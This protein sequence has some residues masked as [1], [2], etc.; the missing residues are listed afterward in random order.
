MEQERL[1]STHPAQTIV[2]S[3]SQSEVL[4]MMAD[5]MSNEAIPG[6]TWLF[7]P[8]S[9]ACGQQAIYEFGYWGRMT[10]RICVRE[11]FGCTSKLTSL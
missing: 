9:G 8:S 10:F 5:G 6:P 1:P 3:Q 4:R 7:D 11:R 2:I